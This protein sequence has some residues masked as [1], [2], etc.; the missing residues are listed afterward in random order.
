MA[1]S[2]MEVVDGWAKVGG[3]SEPGQRPEPETI[4]P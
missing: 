3:A 4:Q 2:G 1:V